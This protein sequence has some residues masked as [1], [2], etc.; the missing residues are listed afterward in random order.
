MSIPVTCPHCGQRGHLSDGK[1]ATGKLKCPSCGKHF[2]PSPSKEASAVFTPT[3]A[4]PAKASSGGSFFRPGRA[5]AISV[6]WA[7]LLWTLF[8][9]V[10]YA[11][12]L[13]LAK[14]ALDALGETC[15]AGPA[16]VAV[17]V[18]ARSVDAITSRPT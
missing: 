16:G 12:A 9:A 18:V 8:V 17:Y 13:V 14:N 10:M 7:C 11:K 3:E 1:A 15:I 5:T 4:A 2:S 6:W